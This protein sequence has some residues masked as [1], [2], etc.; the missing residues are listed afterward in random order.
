VTPTPSPTAET[1]DR[2]VCLTLGHEYCPRSLSLRDGGPELLRLPVIGVLVHDAGGWT[3]LDTG[4]SPTMRDPGRA[5][6]LYRSRSPEFPSPE[7]PLLAA[8]A[9]CG[10]T[11]ADVT[12][13]AVS[14]LHVD[15]SGGLEH[16]AGPGGPPVVIQSRELAFAGTP[17]AAAQGYIAE[18]WEGRDLAWRPIDGDGSIAP[19]VDAV[20][21]P[22][23]T[24]GHMSYRVRTPA[25]PWL[26][27]MDAIDLQEGIDRD[28]EIGSSAHPADAPLRRASHDRLR[29][30][31]AEEDARLIPGHCPQ[32]WP[33]MPGP[34]EG[35]RA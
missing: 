21:T 8:L 16:F 17:A 26:L 10:L 33:T 24:P 12:T 25:G 9:A 19:S 7:D 22:G 2:V 23:H 4:L 5:A 29:A 3:L 27:A 11:A 30:L 34:P 1:A 20:A 15:H 32:T 31:A 35:L 6:A 18:D 28:V 14:H 13:V